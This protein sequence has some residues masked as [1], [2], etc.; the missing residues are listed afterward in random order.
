M[1]KAIPKKEDDV[2]FGGATIAWNT[3]IAEGIWVVFFLVCLVYIFAVVSWSSL[4]NSLCPC[5]VASLSCL[6]I[7]YFSSPNDLS[8]GAATSLAFCLTLSC[9]VLPCLILSLTFPLLPF[10]SL[11]V[12]LPID[13]KLKNVEET[14]LKKRELAM[15]K[16][17]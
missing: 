4:C 6:V 10:G 8:L 1:A 7:K 9:S 12:A 13:Y 15:R 2:D 14:E 17:G 16:V 11:S 3:G 5:V